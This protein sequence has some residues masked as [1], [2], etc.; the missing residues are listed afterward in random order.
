MSRPPMTPTPYTLYPIP[1]RS[2]SPN[3]ASRKNEPFYY[4]Y[5]K[6]IRLFPS[7]NHMMAS[8]AVI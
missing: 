8:A 1:I 6:S 3:Q 7:G 2:P 4:I 5:M